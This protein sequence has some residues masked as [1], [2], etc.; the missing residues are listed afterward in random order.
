[1]DKKIKQKIK[2]Q[3]DTNQRKK[4]KNQTSTTKAIAR[5]STKDKKGS[6]GLNN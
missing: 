4:L 2:A 6:S 3:R 1:M 5:K